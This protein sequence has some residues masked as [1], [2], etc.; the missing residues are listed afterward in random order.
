VL[1]QRLFSESV[2]SPSRH[3]LLKL[4]IPLIVEPLLDSLSKTQKIRVW[5]IRNRCFNLLNAHG[6]SLSLPH[7]FSSALKTPNVVWPHQETVLE[8]Q[9][10]A[11]DR[12]IHLMSGIAA[13][14]VRLPRFSV[15]TERECCE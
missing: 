6:A 11:A 2:K 8:R 4:L 9:Q 3:V 12:P 5:Q 7:E 13:G 1:C 15:A 14:M 10:K